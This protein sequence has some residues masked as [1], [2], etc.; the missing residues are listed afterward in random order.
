MRSGNKTVTKVSGVE[1]F[2]VNPQLLAEELQKAC[3]SSTSVAQLAGSSPRNPVMEI[4][5]QGPQKESVFKAL[6]KRGVGRGWVEVVDKV[7]V[8]KAWEGR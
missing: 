7:K 4:L 6:E 8:K 1:A 5:V 3:A 2:Y